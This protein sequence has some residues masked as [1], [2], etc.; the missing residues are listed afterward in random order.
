MSLSQT[1]I[2]IYHYLTIITIILE[3]CYIKIYI[4]NI[5]FTITLIIT[6]NT[7]NHHNDDDDDHH[8]HHEIYLI[9]ITLL[10]ND[11]HHP[12]Y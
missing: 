1:I 11:H 2:T 6:N 9:I 4:M 3:S 10:S 12:T 5:M 7:L 8:H